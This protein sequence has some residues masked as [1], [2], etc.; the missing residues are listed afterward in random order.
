MSLPTQIGP[1]RVLREIARGGMAAVYEVVDPMSGDHLALKLLTIEGTALQRFNREYEAMIRLNHPNIVRVYAYGEHEGMPWL[2]MELLAGTPVQAY[3]RDQGKPGDKNRLSEVIRLGHDLARALDHIHRRGLVH[4]DLK[5]ANVLVLPDGR[6]KLLDFGTARVADAIE[7]ITK[8]NEFIGTFAYASPEQIEGRALDAR[9][10]LY[11]MGILLYRLFSGVLPFTDTDAQ[12]LAKAQVHQAAKPLGQVVPSIP[13]NVAALVMRLLEKSPEARP[14]TG[15]EVADLLE[16]AAG[17]PL[18]LPGTLELR[19]AETKLI[20]REDVFAS[21]RQGIDAAAPGTTFLIAGQTGSG[22]ERLL[23]MLENDCAARKWRYAKME[24]RS[25]TDVDELLALVTEIGE[26]LTEAATPPPVRA[27][28]KMLLKAEQAPPAKRRDVVRSIG[29]MMFAERVRQD[30]KP[31]VLLLPGLHEASEIAIELIASIQAANLRTGTA[32]YVIATCG[33][34]FD[35]AGSTLRT[36]LP[37]AIRVKL[38][39]LDVAQTARL[40]G[41]LLLRRPPPV[42]IARQIHSASGGQPM[43]VE[44]VVRAM[45]AQGLLRILGRDQNRLDWQQRDGVDIAIADP[46]R[47]AVLSAIA[48]LPVDRRRLIEALALSGGE[49]TAPTLAW[50]VDRDV[51]EI[52]DALH[53]PRLHEIVATAEQPNGEMLVSWRQKLIESAI[54]ERIHPARAD[55]LRRRLAGAVTPETP[56]VPAQIRLLMEVGDFP[57]A[58]IRALAWAETHLN[59]H[60][61][62]TAL[63]GLDPVIGVADDA[64]VPQEDLAQ[65]YLV[66]AASLLAA[67]PTDPQTAR[68]LARAAALGE[69]PRFFAELEFLKARVQRTIG[70]YANYRVALLGAWKQ[71]ERVEGGFDPAVARLGAEIAE[72]MSESLHLSGDIPGANDWARQARTMAI[73]A[74]DA[75]AQVLAEAA[76]AA[77]TLAKGN[78][79]DADKALA[80]AVRH[81]EVK[82][83]L[84]ALAGALVAWSGALRMQGRYSEALEWLERYTPAFRHGEAPS[85]HVRL[86]VAHA[87]CEVELCRLGRAQE[88]VDELFATLRR[89][90]HL[91]LRLEADLV[92]GRIQLA[93]GNASEAAK[94]LGSVADRA[95]T[96]ELVFIEQHARALQAE[97]WWTLGKYAEAEAQFASATEHVQQKGDMAVLQAIC[98]SAVRAMAGSIDPNLLMEPIRTFVEREPALVARVEWMLGFSRFQRASGEDNVLTKDRAR[99]V[100]ARIEPKLDDTARAALRVHPW[101]RELRL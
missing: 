15:G 26:T 97:A 101:N 41:S 62:V 1:Y 56:V 93:S 84:E 32:M 83:D 10:D 94:L 23:Q 100:L 53:D 63:E 69:G 19:D 27:A 12:A 4:R 18:A 47:D 65:L 60:M 67:R 25:G 30:T 31:F 64:D 96:A 16:A 49:A 14:S 58:V 9:A 34:A 37:D 66:H 3:A 24:L 55:V 61:A 17:R 11:S 43:Y 6:L 95:R 42:A 71:I 75:R 35:D 85:T 45:V 20:G 57:N 59:A 13:A 73:R 44:D 36:A 88:L 22:R 81:A 21:L 92:L 99:T 40:V 39:P 8:E 91:H 77:L 76:V 38:Q 54:R 28:V 86:L 78:L 33:E 48:A 89:G 80:K 74:G 5:S 90:E 98:V 72:E 2:T 68:S 29:P 52:R 82:G 50:A 79:R 70:H 46:A 87:W 51:D 7:Q